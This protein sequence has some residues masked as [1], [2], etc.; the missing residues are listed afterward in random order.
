MIQSRPEA[1]ETQFGLAQ[2]AAIEGDFQCGKHIELMI[3]E[4]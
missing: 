2:E 1:P 3:R 4:I